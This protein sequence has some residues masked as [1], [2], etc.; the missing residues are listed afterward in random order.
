MEKINFLF[1]FSLFLVSYTQVSKPDLS[2]NKQR[3]LNEEDRNQ[4]YL[5]GIDN[6]TIISSGSKNHTLYFNIYFLLKNWNWEKNNKEDLNI[7][8]IDTAINYTDSNNNKIQKE[9]TFYCTLIDDDGL[10]K[11]KIVSINDDDEYDRFCIIQFECESRPVEGIP[12]TINITTNFSENQ[13]IKN[14]KFNIS[15]SFEVF[16]KDL[17]GTKNTKL[18]DLKDDK[19]AILRNSTILNKNSPSLKIKGGKYEHGHNNWDSENIQLLTNS[20][21]YP[22]KIPFSGK[23]KK[24]NSD[25]QYYYYLESKGS[26]NLDNTDLNYAL[27]HYT[28]LNKILILDFQEGENSVIE[29]ENV[30]KKKSSG[31]STGGIVAIIIPSVVVLLGVAGLAFFLSRRAVPPIPVKNVANNTIGVAS[32]EAVVHQ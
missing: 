14:T 10:Y 22:K 31:L 24:D 20:H 28:K 15:S 8:Y 4:T 2:L 21:G 6:Y 26:S 5:L 27:M 18:F 25:E 7:F 19:I 13:P 17:I 32:S 16:K 1:L 11:S 30:I 29:K 3:K 23:Y 9:N 12:K